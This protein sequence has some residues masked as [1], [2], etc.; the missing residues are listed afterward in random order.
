MKLRGLLL[1]IML[2]FVA[3]HSNEK[4]QSNFEIGVSSFK[5]GDYLVAEKYFLKVDKEDYSKSLEYLLKIYE[6]KA[7]QV[8]VEKIF[9]EIKKEPDLVF[10]IAYQYLFGN[11]TLE[12]NEAKAKELF[13]IGAK[14]KDT[15]SYIALGNIYEHGLGVEINEAKSKT[16]YEKSGLNKELKGN[17]DKEFINYIRG[18]KSEL[19]LDGMGK[20]ISKAKDYYKIAMDE[21]NRD[22]FTRLGFIQIKENK[23]ERHVK[24]GLI[25]LEKAME[26][27]DSKA[28][29]TLGQIYLNGITVPKDLEKARTYFQKAKEAEIPQAYGV[30]AYMDLFNNSSIDIDYKS[31]KETASLGSKLQNGNSSLVLG[32]LY[33]KGLGVKKNERLAEKYY[34]KAVE[35]GELLDNLVYWY[36]GNLYFYGSKRVQNNEKALNNFLIASEFYEASAYEVGLIYEN[37]YGVDIDIEKAKEYYKKASSLVPKAEERYNE[38]SKG[39]YIKNDEE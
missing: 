5:K 38:L 37:G 4:P 14:N 39:N 20:D 24:N 7:D 28:I 10:N 6:K 15:M 19:G 26:Q 3:C 18:L 30:L 12:I 2:F 17:M 32:Y 8:Q 16:Y 25:Y 22:A 29:M 21:G 35:Q 9:K 1:L 33:Q 27:G 11:E 13:E 31:I 34:L 36:L 23:T